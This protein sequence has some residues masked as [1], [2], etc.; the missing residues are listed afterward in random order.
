MPETYAEQ[1][2]KV[3]MEELAAAQEKIKQ[4]QNR[5]ELA[6]IYLERTVSRLD[7]WQNRHVNYV[8]EIAEILKRMQA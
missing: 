3:L 5:L 7:W 1:Q 6:R 8:A 4:L 2:V